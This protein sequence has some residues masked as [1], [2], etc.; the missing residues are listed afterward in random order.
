MKIYR[1]NPANIEDGRGQVL[2]RDGGEERPLLARWDI[3]NPSP[4]G[5]AWGYPGSGAAQ[6]AVAILADAIGS[7][8]EVRRLY[9]KFAHERVAYLPPR[10]WQMTKAEVVDWMLL[11]L[12]S[13]PGGYKARYDQLAEACLLLTSGVVPGGYLPSI[14]QV[15]YMRA[16]DLMR[17][18]GVIPPNGQ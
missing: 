16:L 8:T 10:G 5:F 3:A 6:L 18:A 1:P 17:E 15:D 14:G 13:L 7:E 12:L 11:Q 2:V 4:D 9:R